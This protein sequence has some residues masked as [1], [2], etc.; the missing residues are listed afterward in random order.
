M[1]IN[2][3]FWNLEQTVRAQIGLAPKNCWCNPGSEYGCEPDQT[4]RCNI[5][6]REMPYCRGAADDM[7]DACD[8]CWAKA[9]ENEEES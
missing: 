9:H 2:K 1:Q 7:E 8:D 6:D 5:C 3:H 4:F